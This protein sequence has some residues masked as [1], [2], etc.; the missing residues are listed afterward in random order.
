MLAVYN[1]MKAICPPFGTCGHWAVSARH[2]C[3]V[4]SA[5]MTP[6]G[7]DNLTEYDYGSVQCFIENHVMPLS[8]DDR[9]VSNSMGV[10]RKT[11]CA[12]SNGYLE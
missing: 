6:Y 11:Y 8:N 2:L 1:G 7:D 5:H 10:L 12:N 9:Y 4:S 3:L